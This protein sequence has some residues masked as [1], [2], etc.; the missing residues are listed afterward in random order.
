MA[1]ALHNGRSRTT[2]AGLESLEGRTFTN[3]GALYVETVNGQ[4]KVVLRIS[5]RRLK[6]L[7]EQL[8]AFARCEVQDVES[9]RNRK[10]LNFTG[11]IAGLTRR[12][13]SEFISRGDVHGFVNG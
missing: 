11:N 4:L 5:E 12:D 10:A 1:G 13:A 6:G 8:S 7:S 2:G 3:D 9:F